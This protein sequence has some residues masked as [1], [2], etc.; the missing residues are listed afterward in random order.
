MAILEILFSN[1]KWF[2]KKNRTYDVEFKRPQVFI[3]NVWL[4][5][6]GLKKQLNITFTFHTYVTLQKAPLL[7]TG[8]WEHC[9]V[10]IPVTTSWHHPETRS[11]S[12][13]RYTE[14]SESR[15]VPRKTY[16]NTHTYM[17]TRTSIFLLSKYNYVKESKKYFETYKQNF[18]NYKFFLF[19]FS[20]NN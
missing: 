15:N 8:L 5:L 7:T 6:N 9:G 4:H 3:R 20:N 2:W 13:C 16:T 10:M 18:L 1:G 11:S 17:N 14:I 12:K 19:W